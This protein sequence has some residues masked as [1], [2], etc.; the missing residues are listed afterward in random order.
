MKR[1]YMKKY[2]E[3]IY[4]NH[5]L[6]HIILFLEKESFPTIKYSLEENLGG[7]KVRSAYNF[8]ISSSNE[9]INI[10]HNKLIGIV[11]EL[12]WLGAINLDDVLDNDIYRYSK[13]S[14][15][16]FF[17]AKQIIAESE[18][19]HYVLSKKISSFPK[20]KK[21]FILQWKN[22]KKSVEL[23]KKGGD[24]EKLSLEEIIRIYI[25]KI[26][27]GVFSA[28]Q[29]QYLIN[30]QFS[31][32][33]EKYAL[34]VGISGQ[35]KNDLLDLGV[36][37]Y[38]EYNKFS[39]LKNGYITYPLL[40]LKEKNKDAFLEIIKNKKQ[41]KIKEYFKKY[42]IINQTMSDV[43]FFIEKAK[44]CLYNINMKK[45][46]LDLLILWAEENRK[47]KRYKDIMYTTPSELAGFF[48]NKIKDI[49]IFF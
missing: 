26:N 33:I 22:G 3:Y 30:P 28:Y 13:Y 42:N 45:N 31:R 29:T 44:E 40:L 19:L 25:Y 4:E 7:V 8:I 32:F 23:E 5:Y 9:E 48:W 43:Y 34:L 20:A 47:F 1:R 21:N 6:S 49:K 36:K 27:C 12:S 37:N 41:D 35:I 11:S 16:K 46:S 10:E 15:L 17:P 18:R 38:K 2:F 24:K 39:D 14:V